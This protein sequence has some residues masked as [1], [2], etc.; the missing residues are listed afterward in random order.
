MRAA[1]RV[2][3]A[4]PAVAILVAATLAATSDP[5]SSESNPDVHERRGIGWARSGELPAEA[6]SELA[7]AVALRPASPYGWAAY[8]EARYRSGTVDA[9]LEAAL[10]FAMELGR[11]EPPVQE[12]V[13]FYGLA[14]WD[15]AAPAT[16]DAVERAVAA[17]MRRDP[18]A[19]MR[20][21]ERRGRLAIACRHVPPASPAAVN[22]GTLCMGSEAR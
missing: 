20:I 21:A 9:R 2:L 15:E 14:I 8:A 10:R 13:A 5:A 18:A 19:M 11:N 3:V 22:H 4:S 6:V 17:G 16:R 1:R 7:T 12:A